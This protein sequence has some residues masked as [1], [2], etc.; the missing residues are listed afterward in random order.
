MASPLVGL[1]VALVVACGPLTVRNAKPKPRTS[2]QHVT[3]IDF[4]IDERVEDR[5]A[6]PASAAFQRVLVEDWRRTLHVGFESAFR[7]RADRA[8]GHSSRVIRLERA[9]VSFEPFGASSLLREPTRGRPEVTVAA[10][11][12]PVLAM[13]SP[14]RQKP[15]PPRQFRAVVAYEALLLDS[16]GQVLR[17]S[18]RRVASR[19]VYGEDSAWSL[20]QTVASAVEVMYEFVARDFADAL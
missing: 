9:E 10:V 4:V 7:Q 15:T 20:T 11:P 8:A 17:R 1:M 18:A 12:A 5:F 19:R 13:H 14:N 3:A 2:L 6:I 16:D